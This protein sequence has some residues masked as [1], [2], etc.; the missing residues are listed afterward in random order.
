MTYASAPVV[1]TPT[2]TAITDTTATLGA[3]VTDDG[4]SALTSRGT[5]WDTS[6]SPTANA[7]AE[8]GTSTGVFSHSRSGLTAGTL[9]YY[10]GYAVNAVGTSYSA[11]GTFYT[12]AVPATTAS[13][14]M[15][16]TA[17]GETSMT[18]NWTSGNGGH[19]LVIA[20]AGSA[21]SGTPANATAY[22]ANATYGSGQALAGGYVVY[23]GTGSSVT[24]SG[25]TAS[26]TYY[27][28]VYEYNEAGS[29]VATINYL[30]SSSLSGSQAT[31][32][33]TSPTISWP[34]QT[35]GGGNPPWNQ[36]RSLPQMPQART[37]TS[38]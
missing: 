19:R 34:G 25:L 8:G 36:C 14:G 9:Y 27:F 37:R 13:S 10:R 31:T 24:V 3:N 4:G 2:A 29:T 7:L 21:P 22:T 17:V 28:V 5:V 23:D 33:A 30:T 6:P 38:T 12:L 20:K 32:A 16:F 11:D 1:T 35:G 26:T 18:V 15:N